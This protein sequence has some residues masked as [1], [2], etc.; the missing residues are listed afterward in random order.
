MYQ[1]I[2]DQHDY[3]AV[4]FTGKVDKEEY[5]EILAN[6]TSKT[7]TGNQVDLLVDLTELERFTMGALWEDI[8]FDVKNFKVI[9]RLATIGDRNTIKI[10][11]PISKPFVTDEAKFFEKSDYKEAQKWVH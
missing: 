9:R 8:K 6:L 11:D 1:V 5:Q 3:L 10:L 7:E 4:K 2:S